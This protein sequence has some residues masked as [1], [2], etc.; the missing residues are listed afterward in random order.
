MSIYF[1]FISIISRGNIKKVNL[2]FCEII[3]AKEFKT[4]INQAKA[5]GFKNLIFT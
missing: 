1:E 4:K 5:I 3:K 2:C